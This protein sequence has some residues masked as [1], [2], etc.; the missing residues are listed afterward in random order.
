ME[1]ASRELYDHLFEGI[2]DDLPPKL[3]IIANGKLLDVPFSVLRKDTV[4]E[5]P[6]YLGVEH[7]ISRQFSL[8]TMR[9]LEET[10]LNASYA[11]PLAMAPSFANEFLQASELR[12]AGFQ[13]PPL[14]YNTEE[15]KDLQS[16]RGGK[17]LYDD[18]ATIESYRDKVS[19]LPT[20]QRRRTNRSIRRR[21]RRADAQQ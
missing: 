20:R 12:Q 16:R 6:S 2:K 19:D 3:H 5:A 9:L 15:L 4:G 8:S 11:Q 1:A 21:H 18:D 14:V 13:L 10:E 7:A 17:Y